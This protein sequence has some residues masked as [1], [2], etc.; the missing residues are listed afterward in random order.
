M[1]SKECCLLSNIKRTLIEVLFIYYTTLSISS[2]VVNHFIALS[3]PS[4]FM[5]MRSQLRASEMT[6]STLP[7]L[8]IILRIVSLRV[9]IS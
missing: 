4:S 3:I 8:L 2:I 9:I 5:V 7:Q 6:S 1:E